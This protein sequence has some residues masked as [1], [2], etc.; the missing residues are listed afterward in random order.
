MGLTTEYPALGTIYTVSY[1]TPPPNVL[2]HW[3]KWLCGY[4]VKKNNV[5]PH[6]SFYSKIYLKKLGG[7]VVQ[8]TA[9]PHSHFNIYLQKLVGGVV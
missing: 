1:T 8:L 3:M 9:Y 5:K 2:K 7:G 4:A 6:S